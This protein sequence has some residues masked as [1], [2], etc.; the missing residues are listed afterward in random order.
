M[1]YFDRHNTLLV[2]DA[3]QYILII[4]LALIHKAGPGTS[5]SVI[6]CAL[7]HVE[8][9]WTNK[10]NGSNSNFSFNLSLITDENTMSLHSNEYYC[11][12]YSA[13]RATATCINCTS[14]K[15]V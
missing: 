7:Q 8:Q 9:R 5:A 14:T 12:L 4:E 2:Y 13:F 10:N 6:V 1:A 15:R 3:Y 11:K